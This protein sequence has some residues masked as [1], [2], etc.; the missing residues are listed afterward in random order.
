MSTF[1]LQEHVDTSTNDILFEEKE[2]DEDEDEDGLYDQ[3]QLDNNSSGIGTCSG[4]STSSKQE[5]YRKRFDSG[6]VRLMASRM[7]RSE[8]VKFGLKA[9]TAMSE[10]VS[11]VL[12]GIKK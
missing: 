8:S 12:L 11:D 3:D 9:N 4:I 1:R 10:M 2:E 6:K 7:V 5:G